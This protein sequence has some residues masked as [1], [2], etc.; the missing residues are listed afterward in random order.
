MI[1]LNCPNCGRKNRHRESSAGLL[2]KC[3]NC[4]ADYSFGGSPAAHRDR[5]GIAAKVR[6]LFAS[7]VRAVVT[8]AVVA[9]VAI[10]GMVALM[11]WLE[12][13]DTTTTSP[14][15][16]RHSS[17]P[18]ASTSPP[19]HPATEITGVDVAIDEEPQETAAAAPEEWQ[20]T[21]EPTE[22]ET[23]L[24]TLRKI[25]KDSDDLMAKIDRDHAACLAAMPET[26]TEWG[27]WHEMNR[28][29][30][31]L[32]DRLDAR[33]ERV[34]PLQ[35]R[36]LVGIHGHFATLPLRAVSSSSDRLAKY[37]EL[38]DFIDTARADRDA[39]LRS[40]ASHE[41]GRLR[42]ELDDPSDIRIWR[43]ATGQH[44]TQARLIQSD[45]DRVSLEK[46]D[47]ST[48]LVPVARLS[49][50]DQEYLRGLAELAELEAF[51][52]AAAD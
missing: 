21:Y 8:L 27:R 45:G 10:A 36:I 49:V 19:S 47:G 41:I 4:G 51:A 34:Q 29:N 6:G 31:R 26:E 30:Q 46:A 52:A 12:R 7:V 14:P 17:A 32:I 42:E 13:R 40:F 18:L 38:R 39:Y 23:P 16:A 28:T 15:P 37:R 44:E 5:G 24:A 3:R 22:G 50:A 20:P 25:A 33:T 48:S 2:V 11:L 1:T 9:V 43:D 35:A